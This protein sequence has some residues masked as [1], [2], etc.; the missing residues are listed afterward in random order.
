MPVP[1]AMGLSLRL[2]NEWLATTLVAL[3]MPESLSVHSL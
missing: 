1:E 3:Q 2:R